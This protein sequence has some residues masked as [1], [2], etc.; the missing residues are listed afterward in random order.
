MD[1]FSRFDIDIEW[2]TL[3]YTIMYMSKTINDLLEKQ[4]EY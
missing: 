4:K 2:H 3:N 1:R